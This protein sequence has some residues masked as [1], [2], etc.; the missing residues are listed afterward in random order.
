MILQMHVCIVPKKSTLPLLCFLQE[1]GFSILAYNKVDGKRIVIED[2]KIIPLISDPKNWLY[3][4]YSSRGIELSNLQR[5]LA[6]I[7]EFD[8][9]DMPVFQVEKNPYSIP[10]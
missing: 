1:E 6:K 10:R 5:F 2:I 4:A 9:K 8:E 3:E 7:A